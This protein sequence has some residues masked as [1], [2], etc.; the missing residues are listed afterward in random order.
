[1]SF[2]QSLLRKNRAAARILPAVAAILICLASS[3]G[4]TPVTVQQIGITPF[5][6]ISVRVTGAYTGITSAGVSELLVNGTLFDG[7]C[8]DPF[9]SSIPGAQHYQTVP[10]TNATERRPFDPWSTYDRR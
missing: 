10:L 2:H 6:T 7:F 5:E 9:H 8:I 4:A 1:M 3:L